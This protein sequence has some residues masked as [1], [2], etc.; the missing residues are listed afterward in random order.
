MLG[1]FHAAEDQ[2]ENDPGDMGYSPLESIGGILI[3]ALLA[4]LSALRA[5]R[6]AL[7]ETLWA[8]VAVMEWHFQPAQGDE[9][10]GVWPEVWIEKARRLVGMGGK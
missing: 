4:E 1:Q 8:G 9:D 3:D 6:E 7:R 5:E 10:P 2:K